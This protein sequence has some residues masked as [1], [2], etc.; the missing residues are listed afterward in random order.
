MSMYVFPEKKKGKLGTQT[1][2]VGEDLLGEGRELVRIFHAKEGPGINV[3]LHRS[4]VRTHG[5]CN[6]RHNHG[7]RSSASN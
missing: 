5:G 7:S 1:E 2:V 6:Y 3:H 4:A